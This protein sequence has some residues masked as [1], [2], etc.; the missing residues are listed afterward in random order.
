MPPISDPGV[1]APHQH[2]DYPEDEDDYS[3]SRSDY[4]GDD[5]DSR[6]YYSD[7]DRSASG[8]SY[9]ENGE[10][11]SYEKQSTDPSG[12]FSLG[13]DSNTNL[14]TSYNKKETPLEDEEED[15]SDSYETDTDYN[16]DDIEHD[17]DMHSA[18][19]SLEDQAKTREEVERIRENYKKRFGDVDVIPVR[20]PTR[21]RSP[22][23]KLTP[24]SSRHSTDD[25]FDKST[26]TKGIR[27]H[28]QAAQAQM[29]A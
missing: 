3:R 18:M 21:G 4:S 23:Q 28:E 1:A 17:D 29:Q 19:L 22:T 27:K 7:E 8:G 6:S 15:Y 25:N 12:R 14:D 26:S 9:S 10:S 13:S 11:A 24:N 16:Q 20:T 5:N 2:H